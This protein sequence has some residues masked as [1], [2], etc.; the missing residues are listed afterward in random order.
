MQLQD[1]TADS[2][3]LTQGTTGRVQVNDEVSYV[4]NSVKATVDA[5]TGKV[6][7]YQADDQDPV[8]KTWM[9]VFPG[10]VKSKGEYDANASLKKHVRY[11]EDLFKLQRE[12]LTRYHVDNASTFFRAN[13]FWSVPADPAPE[14][15][16][17]L[18]Q[19]PYY[20]T[21]SSPEKENQARFQLTTV[22]NALNRPNLAAYL[23]AESDPEN[24][25]KLTI[26]ELPTRP[27]GR[28]L[29]LAVC[30]R[31]PTSPSATF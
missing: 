15:Q 8:L 3:Q 25:G 19:P 9:K 6:E 16:T 11:P 14:E 18:K 13:N 31:T 21:A 2:R 10:T 20:F 22:M 23:T 30:W 4:R 26:K 1:A 28:W 12:L 27:T 29:R 7:L 17:N 24:Y 5:Y